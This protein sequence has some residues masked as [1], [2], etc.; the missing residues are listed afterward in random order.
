MKTLKENSE[1][2][3]WKFKDNF[4]S[5]H[6]TY[7]AVWHTSTHWRKLTVNELFDQSKLTSHARNNN[8]N[9]NNNNNNNDD[10]RFS[11]VV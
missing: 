4:V 11:V 8:D 10:N 1:N 3:K 5:S 2:S 7:C 9:S 6:C